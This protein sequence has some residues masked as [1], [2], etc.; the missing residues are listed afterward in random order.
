MSRTTA[1]PSDAALHAAEP[2]HELQR[3]AIQFLADL[4]ALPFS[5]D[6]ITAGSESEL[7]AAVCGRSE[8]VDLPRTIHAS[9]YVKNIRER[10][11]AGDSP[12]ILIRQL[13]EVLTSSEATVWENSWVRFP[14]RC[15]NRPATQLLERDLAADKRAPQGPRRA[16]VDR[17]LLVEQG[18]S[19]SGFLSAIS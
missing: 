3:Q 17:Y 2:R 6:D 8:D 7:Q 16:D 13:Q 11:A 4:P 15:L 10:T 12:R 18:R 1:I 19:G 5:H 14:R 9:N